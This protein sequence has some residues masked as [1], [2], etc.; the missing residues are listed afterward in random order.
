VYLGSKDRRFRLEECCLQKFWGRSKLT[1]MQDSTCGHCYTG[2]PQSARQTRVTVRK[3]PTT[4]RQRVSPMTMVQS[5]ASA[6][7]PAEN[8]NASK[9]VQA[10]ERGDAAVIAWLQNRAGA[11]FVYR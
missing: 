1:G 10:E 7:K 6:E 5:C 9:V 2:A 3:L 4:S 8:S 11:R